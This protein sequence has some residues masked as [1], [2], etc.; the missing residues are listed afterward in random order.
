MRLTAAQ[1]RDFLARNPGSDEARAVVGGSPKKRAR[2]RAR[3]QSLQVAVVRLIRP[4]LAGIGG[5]LLLVGGEIRAGRG[6]KESQGR[7]ARMQRERALA[8]Y[9]VGQPD[10]LAAWPPGQVLFVELK[11]PAEKGLFGV[12]A[13]AG[14]Q[15]RSQRDFEAWCEAAGLGYAV[16]RSPDEVYD[17]LHAHGAPLPPAPW[18]AR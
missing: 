14:A 7:F 8:G 13:P 12:A 18:R 4:L 10:L 2:P 16:C 3:E 15:R 5:K 1:L 9:E 17:A 6:G 11:A